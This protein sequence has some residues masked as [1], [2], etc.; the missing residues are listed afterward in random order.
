MV[1]HMMIVLNAPRC[2]WKNST[3]AEI[4]VFCSTISFGCLVYRRIPGLERNPGCLASALTGKLSLFCFRIDESFLLILGSVTNGV[5]WTVDWLFGRS[6]C[7][8]F[9]N[10]LQVTLPCS[11]R[12]TC[13]QTLKRTKNIL[14]I[15]SW[16]NTYRVAGKLALQTFRQTIRPFASLPS[17]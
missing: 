12:S 5:C 13:F 8:N 9:P 7:H 15:R 16:D 4:L 11:Y 1:A 17:K 3:W 14:W 10:G 2:A 6:V